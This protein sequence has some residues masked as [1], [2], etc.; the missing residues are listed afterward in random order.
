MS[1]RIHV[2]IYS[3]PGC[4]LCDDAKDVVERVRERHP[5]VLRIINI[6]TDEFTA[7]CPYSGLPDFATVKINYIPRSLIIELRSFKY[8]LKMHF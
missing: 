3:R 6:E 4:H 1:D 2:D 5:F 7:V 8:Y